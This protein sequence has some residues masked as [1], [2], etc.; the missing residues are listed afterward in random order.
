[1]NNENK[2]VNGLIMRRIKSKANPAPAVSGLDAISD[3]IKNYSFVVAYL[4]YKV[5]IGKYSDGSFCFNN[6]ETI[7]P[8]YIQ[9]IRIFNK[10][11]ELLLWRCEGILKGRYRNDNQGKEVWAVENNQVLFGTRNPENKPP[12]AN[13]TTIIEDR[14]TEITLP[15][16][17]K[18]NVDEHKNRV[19]IKTLNY[20]CFNEIHQATYAD[21]RFVEFTFGENNIPLEV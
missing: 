1:M 19:K 8:N 14:G 2:P 9:R 10:N 20:I 11:E 5:I 6:N 16:K 15:F 7:E 18:I 4:D 3:I 12:T 21:S 17:L 13:S